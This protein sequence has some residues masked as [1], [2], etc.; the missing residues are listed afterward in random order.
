MRALAPIGWADVGEW[1]KKI[2]MAD[3]VLRSTY[4]AHTKKRVISVQKFLIYSSI[5]G[6]DRC[7]GS[8]LVRDGEV[9]QETAAAA[10]PDRL[11]RDGVVYH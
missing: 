5:A 11:I 1:A 8:R 4:D 3:S 7:C 10:V 2:T 6:G 9:Y